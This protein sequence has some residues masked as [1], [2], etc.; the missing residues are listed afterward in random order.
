MKRADFGYTLPSELIAQEPLKSRDRARLLVID[1]KSGS[2]RHDVFAN[3]GQY[4]PPASLLVVNDSK[5]IPARLLGHR[6]GSGGKVEVFVLKITSDDGLADVLIR[7]LRRMHDGDELIFDDG[8]RAVVV[9]RTRP[10]VRFNRKGVLAFLNKQGHI[11]LPPYIDR[12]DAPRDRTY[13]QTVYAHKWGSVAAPTAGLHFTKALLTTLA[14]QGHAMAKVTLHVNYGTFKPVDEEDITQHQIHT[15]EYGVTQKT[16]QA[17]NRAKKKRQAV[18][19]VGT[20]SCRVLETL[21]GGKDLKGTTNLF[22]YPGYTFKNVDAL[23]TNFHLPYSTLL[24]LV[25]AFGSREL[26]MAAYL[27]AIKNKY[28][29]YSYGDAML[30]I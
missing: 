17:L 14:A 1:R 16:R 12:Q 3:V 26:I 8:V 7:P 30:I 24:M 2:F 27:E 28:R 15:E 22:I 13:Y 25:S 23:I 5:V 4:L 20:T 19:A 6:A 29:F 11:P 9:D 18:V 21:A 10:S